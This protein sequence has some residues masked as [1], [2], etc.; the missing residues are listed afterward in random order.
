MGIN[1]NEWK[2]IQIAKFFVVLL[3]YGVWQLNENIYYKTSCEIVLS[4]EN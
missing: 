1:A 4:I 2:N 3:W